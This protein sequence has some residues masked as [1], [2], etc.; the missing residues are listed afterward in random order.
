[1]RNSLFA[2]AMIG[3]VMPYLL[4]TL[5]TVIA[6][7]VATAQIS[8]AAPSPAPTQHDVFIRM[9]DGVRLGADI[10]LP[11]GKGPFP[12][13]LSITPYGKEVPGQFSVDWIANGYAIVMVDSRG[14][15]SSGGELEFYTNEGHDGFDIQQWIGH[16]RWCNG[17][18][19]M[20]GTSYPAYVQLAP[21]I[22]RSKFVKAII[23]VAA[24]QDNFSDVWSSDGIL[25]PAFGPEVSAWLE[26]EHEKK[27]L[28]PVD[29]AEIVWT[30]PLKAIPDKLPIRP[31]FW[32]KVLQHESYDDFWR[33]MSFR[34][35][36]SQMD[37][38]AL[39]VSGWYDDLSNDT[40]L[41]FI[42]MSRSSRSQYSRHWQHLLIGPW[43]HGV[44]HF[45]DGDWIYDD[46]N[47]G[48]AA[49]VNFDDVQ[50]RWFDFH[51]KGIHNG[52]DQDA[53][54]RIFV[55]GTNVWRNE[56][57]WPL[58]RAVPTQYYLHSKGFANTRFGN[59]TLNQAAPVA[60]KPDS[61][62]YDPRNP[63]PT[64]G[65]HGCCDFDFAS[66]GPFDQSVTE[67]RP[68][69][70]VYTTPPLQDDVEVTG[71]PEA[72]LE[73]STDVVDTD[74]FVTLT[75]VFPDGRSILITE[76]SLRARFR[77]SLE[78]PQLLAPNQPD[79]VV[80]HLWGTSNVFKK[81]HRI[82]VRITS[83]NFPRF[84][85]NL[86]SGKP[87]AEEAEDDI[88]VATTTIFHASGR[89]SALVLPI[90]PKQ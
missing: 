51:L 36:Y 21:A 38:P 23:P 35:H 11:P 55:M 73:F 30:L 68:D 18:I 54:V 15:H 62:R 26:A 5:A 89:V 8:T 37:V 9:R 41:N 3:A 79:S 69:V 72:H 17:R 28:P 2:K 31:S 6:S 88:R 90:I 19:G 44:P 56:Q 43:A 32:E 66:V 70:L 83:S 25:H 10:Y 60:E 77:S 40:Q 14:K 13:L 42:E 47:F 84:S 29:W 67:Q 80:V 52:V 76:G 64:H 65:G 71:F 46:V 7:T 33:A 53:P 49:K 81:G 58:S 4:A 1:M 45:P 48:T 57:E 12:V 78:R 27:P 24:Q 85:R 75:D 50:R 86:N 59:G 22:Y 16:Q 34:G 39:H 87:A 20:F 82:R 63:V 61:F 74:F